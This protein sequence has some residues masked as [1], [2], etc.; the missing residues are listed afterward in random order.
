[1]AWRQLIEDGRDLGSL[2]IA[3][4]PSRGIR[5]TPNP[6]QVL[7]QIIKRL[8]QVLQLLVQ[9]PQLQRLMPL[10]QCH[11]L[12]LYAFEQFTQVNR[13]LVVIGN[14]GAQCL[15]HILLVRLPGEHD[16]FEGPVFTTQALQFLD[17]LNAV[18][19]RHVQIA[20]DQAN[21][22]V[23]LETFDRLMAGFAGNA[24]VA[25][26]LKKFAKF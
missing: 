2:G 23:L 9:M 20:E 21:V 5:C 12:A 15:D 22:H 7:V 24:A 17:H 11:F 25:V 4:I 26:A 13:L 10:L 18:Q 3:G 16:G 6:V 8:G 14:A 1:M 19:A